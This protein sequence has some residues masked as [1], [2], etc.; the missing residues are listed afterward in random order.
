MDLK[1]QR[2]VY[3]KFEL[4]EESVKHNP[5]DQFKNW[6]V[7]TKNSEILEAN[8]MTL[9]TDSKYGKPSARIVLLK[10]VTETGFVFFT[11]YASQKGMDL[12]EN[13]QAEILFFWDALERQ[14]RISGNV[15]KISQD[16]SRA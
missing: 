12:A 7:D 5:F 6:F 9:A 14:V 15:K 16:E 2:K 11:N 8:A 10:E 3:E 1:D 4:H 13:P